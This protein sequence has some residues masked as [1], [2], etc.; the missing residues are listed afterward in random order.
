MCFFW[1]NSGI[2]EIKFI[3]HASNIVILKVKVCTFLLINTSED[4]IQYFDKIKCI[5]LLKN[6]IIY[7]PP[8]RT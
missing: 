7:K 6:S 5:D 1:R 2:S 3:H 4:K 8:F